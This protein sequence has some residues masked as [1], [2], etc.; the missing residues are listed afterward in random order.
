[1]IL[2][3]T[4]TYV[5]IYFL[6]DAEF[7][8]MILLSQRKDLGKDTSIMSKALARAN[9]NI[10][11]LLIDQGITNIKKDH[12]VRRQKTIEWL[13]LVHNALIHIPGEKNQKKVL[14]FLI[15]KKQDITSPNL[16]YNSTPLHIAIS[17]NCSI[18]IV[19]LLLAQGVPVNVYDKS[20]MSPLHKALSISRNSQ[21]DCLKALLEAGSDVNTPEDFKDT[22]TPMAVAVDRRNPALMQLLMH[23]GYRCSESDKE[24]IQEATSRLGTDIVVNMAELLSQPLALSSLCAVSL[25]L[26]LGRRLDSYLSVMKCPKSVRDFVHWKHLIEK[27]ITPL[28]K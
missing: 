13:P 16:M 26:G 15:E 25:R 21:H 22:R 28:P 27:Y 17:Q 19:E 8:A 9:I 3:I 1:M 6:S 12:Y 2:F 24:K 23:C 14:E 20:G 18:E 10:I 11:N 7:I 4:P 5:L